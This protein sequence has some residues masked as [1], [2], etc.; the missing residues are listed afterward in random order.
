MFKIDAVP[1][2]LPPA[3]AKILNIAVTSCQQ[4]VLAAP[5]GCGNPQIFVKVG[6][7]DAGQYARTVPG[8]TWPGTMIPKSCQLT[9][10]HKV[11]PTISNSLLTRV[12]LHELF[13]CLGFG[14]S[15][16]EPE[17]VQPISGAPH[18]VG[19]SALDEYRQLLLKAGRA[20]DVKGIP[21]QPYGAKG[22]TLHW[23]DDHFKNELM[24]TSFEQDQAPL[25]AMSIA[26]LRDLGYTVNPAVA[27]PY[28]LPTV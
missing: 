6:V 26:A 11:L 28:M 13:H 20:G 24:T 22:K 5:K 14:C 7:T 3:V 19:K 1:M 21:L 4:I 8:G 12:L 18:Y 27:E 16:T 9:I 15:W 23:S 2:S 25:S 10:E 17:L